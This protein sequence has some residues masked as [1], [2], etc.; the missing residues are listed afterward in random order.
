MSGDILDRML[1]R[2]TGFSW[3]GS[4]DDPVPT[5]IASMP[6]RKK[7]DRSDVPCPSDNELI[8]VYGSGPVPIELRR[9][10]S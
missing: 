6:E 5:M 4:L 2:L 10:G 9:G 7:T 8:D 3:S 1:G